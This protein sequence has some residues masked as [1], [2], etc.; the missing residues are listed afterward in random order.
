MRFFSRHLHLQLL[1]YGLGSN[2]VIA[3]IFSEYLN[4]IFW[5]TTKSDVSPDDLPE[6]SI[7]LVAVSAILIITALCIW[8]RKLGPRVAVVFTAVKVASL[9][10]DLMLVLNILHIFCFTSSDRHYTSGNYS[11]GSRESVDV[12]NDILV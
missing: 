6:W 3:L 11:V 10:C 7:K 2:A 9:V 8:A 5:H 12:V 1:I 4:R